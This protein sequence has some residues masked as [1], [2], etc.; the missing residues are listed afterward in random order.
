MAT[1]SSSI[2]RLR[3]ARERTSVWLCTRLDSWKK[4]L[5]IHSSFLLGQANILDDDSSSFEKKKQHAV[6]YFVDLLFDDRFLFSDWARRIKP[7]ADFRETPANNYAALQQEASGGSPKSAVSHWTLAG[8]EQRLQN[9]MVILS[10]HFIH[11]AAFVYL[12]KEIFLKIEGLG[13]Q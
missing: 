13:E 7:A 9:D 8:Q 12:K 5:K 2:G 4:R 1:C 6:A 11:V 3:H 10:F